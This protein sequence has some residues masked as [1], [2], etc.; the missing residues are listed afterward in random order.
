VA[1]GN[2]VTAHIKLH[3]G[4]NF[5]GGR[6][7]LY[8][9]IADNRAESQ[10]ARGENAGRSLTHVAVTRVLKLASAVDL[11]SAATKDVTLSVPAGSS[12]SRLVSVTFHGRDTK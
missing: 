10:V 5:K 2:R 1:P 3:A 9:A 4:H 12:G 11:D 6:G 7:V 8:V